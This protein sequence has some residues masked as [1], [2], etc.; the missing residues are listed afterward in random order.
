M[1]GLG[2][3]DTTTVAQSDGVH[4]LDASRERGARYEL[5]GTNEAIS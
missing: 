5:Y 2:I 4:E 1:R 3:D